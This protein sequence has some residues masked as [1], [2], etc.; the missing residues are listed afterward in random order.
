MSDTLLL[1]GHSLTLAD[2]GRVAAEGGPRVDLAPRARAQ[3]A[4]AR[5][6]IESRI[7][8]GESVYGVTTGFGRLAEVVIPPAD[9]IAL[10]RNVIR[11]HAAGFGEPMPR[12]V[13]RALMLLRANTLAHGHSGCTARCVELL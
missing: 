10:Q 5:A 4:A 12:L 8:A 11:S 7:A 13:V 6:V 2:I 9:R 1:D 3:L